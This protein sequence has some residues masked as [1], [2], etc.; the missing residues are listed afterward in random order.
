MY[1]YTTPTIAITLSDID[2]ADVSTFR[3]AIE[4]GSVELVKAIPVNDSQVDSTNKT[5]NMVLTQEET[6]S[7][8]KG[9]GKLQVRVVYNNGTV[10]A[11]P[12]VN[13]EVND[14]LD[15]VEV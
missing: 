4:K 6:A 15:E 5:I 2:F 8:S 3:V 12:T 14:V 13:V 9:V 11:T 10:L 7:F 1:R